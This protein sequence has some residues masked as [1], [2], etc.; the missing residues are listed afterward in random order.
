MLFLGTVVF[1]AIFWM[2]QFASIEDARAQKIVQV[3]DK[4]F[5]DAYGKVHGARDSSD[6]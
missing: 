6:Y 2:F 1:G 5:E 3:M 4:F